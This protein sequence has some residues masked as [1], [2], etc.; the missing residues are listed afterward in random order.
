MDWN[1]ILASIIVGLG[2]GYATCWIFALKGGRELRKEAGML[3]DLNVLMLRAMQHA[4][5]VELNIVDGVPKGI[6]F[7]LSAG[8]KLGPKDDIDPKKP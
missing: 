6:V 1:N 2:T 8:D 3:R 5:F 7:R 4:G